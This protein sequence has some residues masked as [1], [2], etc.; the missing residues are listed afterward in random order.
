VRKRYGGQAHVHATFRGLAHTTSHTPADRIEQGTFEILNRVSRRHIDPKPESE[1]LAGLGFDSLQVLE[2]IG[3]L[4]DRF[5]I[6]VPLNDLPHVRT[7][8]DVVKEV[9]RLVALQ[10]PSS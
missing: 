5:N 3:E 6:D 7:V 2:L 8:A 1:L 10:E 9:R 4:E